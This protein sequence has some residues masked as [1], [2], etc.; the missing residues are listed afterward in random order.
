MTYEEALAFIHGTYKFGSKLGLENIKL[1]LEKLGSPE[2]SLKFIHVA[3]TNGK[4]STCAFIQS[5]LIEAG[6]ST[7]L[8]TSPFIE[9]F[10]ERIRVNHTLIT[11]DELAQLTF[12]VKLKV[13][14]MVCEG[15]QHPTEFEVVTAIAMLYYQMKQCDVVVL[16][17]GLGGRLDA[18]N[19]IETPLVSVITPLDYDHMEY[20]GHTL[21]AIAGEKA[22]IIKAGGTTVTYPQ[23]DEAQEVIRTVC[24]SQKNAL[25][26]VSFKDLE[27][28]SV[29]FGSLH[30][31]YQETSYEIG[32]FAPYQAENAVVAIEVLKV[33]KDVHRFS[34][35]DE[36]IASGLKKAKWIGRLEIVSDNPFIIIDGAHNMHGI[37]GLAKSI[38]V[39]GKAYRLVGIVGILKDKDVEGM[40]NVI[41]PYLDQVITTKPDNPRAM[42][43]EDLATYFDASKVIGH[44]ESIKEAVDKV[45]DLVPIADRPTLYLGFGSLYMIG[46]IR[47]HVQ[48]RMSTSQK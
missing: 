11:S 21:S 24:Y 7:G 20:L 26:E 5:V 23:A 28:L 18:T 3:G 30:F 47:S 37:R 19:V 38:D 15:H 31:N 42:S 45:Y 40:I 1:L 17:V 4:G 10:N 14:E 36:H 48:R 9:T 34:L 43:A 29:E 39:L 46:D 44:Y 12:K 35:T 16:E 8:Y 22:G 32:L 27:I 6:Y 2:K 13:D 25:V 41:S 33:L